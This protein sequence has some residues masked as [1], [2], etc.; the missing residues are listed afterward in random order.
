MEET[1]NSQLEHLQQFVQQNSDRADVE[2]D[3]F[4]AYGKYPCLRVK[5]DR[6]FFDMDF[7]PHDNPSRNEI[8]TYFFFKIIDNA[9]LPRMKG[10][11]LRRDA[12]PEELKVFS[13]SRSDYHFF[14]V[15]ISTWADEMINTVK[16][17][18][19]NLEEFLDLCKASCPYNEDGSAR[20]QEN[21]L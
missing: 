9:E 17:I 11:M 18:Q 8:H 7:K 21:A 2:L 10:F 16:Y 14:P 3:L 1:Y 6:Y 12:I 19:A 13:K 20:L 4:P 15:T 5:V